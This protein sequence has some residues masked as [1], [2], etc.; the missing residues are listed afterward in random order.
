VPQPPRTFA[1]P[2]KSGVRVFSQGKPTPVIGFLV[3]YDKDE[4]G[5]VCELRSGRWLLSSQVVDQ[6]S[7]IMVDD[8]TISPLHA[9]IRVGKNGR[10]QVLDQLSEYGTGLLR[11]DADQEEEVSG[12]MVEVEHGD[13][14][15]FGKRKFVVCLVPRPEVEEE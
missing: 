2:D 9:I 13:M 7:Y 15:R 6:G 4:N 12:A 3:S 5:Q 14:V 1:E 11:V 10:I 8:E